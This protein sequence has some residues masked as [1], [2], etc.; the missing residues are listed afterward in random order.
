MPINPS[1]AHP[2]TLSS[3][4]SAAGTGT[5]YASDN[6]APVLFVNTVTG[7]AG[8]NG[9]TPANAM[10][11]I[12]EAFAAMAVWE[13]A[14]PHSADNT[15]I[16]VL[17]VIAEQLTTPLSGEAGV[18][19]SGVTINGLVGGN[20]RHD[21]GAR[22]KEAASAGA[23][24]LLTVRG[25]GW[26][27]RHLLMVPQTGYFAVRLRRQEDNT[28]PDGSHA[29]FDNVRFMGNAALGTAAGGGIEDYGGNYNVS[30]DGCQFV[31]LIDGIKMT[32]ASI[33][34]PLMWRVGVK[35]K[36]IFQLNTNDISLNSS[37]GVFENNQFM[38][39]YNVTTHP[40]TINLAFTSTTTY[41]NRVNYNDF[42][43]AAGN[44]VIAKGYVKGNTSDVW[45]NT[46]TDT[47]AY[48][49]TVP[50]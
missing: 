49:V 33:A 2:G 21:D 27:F 39:P 40:I 46:V 8:N 26:T 1:I 18:G 41:G 19:V 11:T 31:N 38:T 35:Q 14:V 29:V 17:G 22:W 47:A 44:V 7:V 6:N 12:A 50:S 30:V 34:A 28:Y 5:A 42:A 37:G 23:A 48:I 15:I 10:P 4:Q 43:D 16:N 9:L 3:T 20:N 24:P 13:A 45:R 25:Q 32:N 36:N